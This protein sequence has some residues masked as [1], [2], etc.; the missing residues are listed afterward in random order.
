MRRRSVI[1]ALALVGCGGDQGEKRAFPLLPG[2]PPP[3]SSGPVLLV[4]PMAAA[5]GLEV[6]GLRRARADGGV[7]VDFWNEWLAPPA[8]LADAALR[9]LLA[10]RFVVVAPGSAA[11]H[12]LSLETELLALEADTAANLARAS[13]GAVLT[14]AGGRVLWQ[15]APQATVPLASGRA[16]DVVAACNAALAAALAQI[17]RALTPR[18]RRVA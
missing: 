12:V 13:L 11:T 8:T 18:G 15:G 6:R 9:R 7:E 2:G 14:D 10:R 17:D 16:A 3:A 1:A 4:R 5:P